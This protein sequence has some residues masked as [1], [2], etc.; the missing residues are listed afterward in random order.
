MSPLERRRADCAPK[1]NRSNIL[2]CH[3]LS[4]LLSLLT[5]SSAWAVDPSLHISQYAHTAWR[6]QDGV[7][8]G[9]PNTVTQTADGYLWIGTQAGLLRFDGVRFI[10]WTPPD[11]KRLP[12]SNVISLWG[13]RDGSLWIGMEGGLSHWDNRDLATYLIEPTR[14]NSII[15]DRSGTV[16]FVR[17]RG[18]E[19]GRRS[20]PDHRDKHGVLRKSRW[21]AWCQRGRFSR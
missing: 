7:F 2:R 6:I 5:A 19:S 18:S 21:T 14:I 13:A 11:G 4:L 20:L 16:W 12:S 3:F 9:A 15:E 10:P 8:S 17:S 1:A